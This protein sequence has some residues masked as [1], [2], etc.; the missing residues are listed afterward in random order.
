MR[1]VPFL[2]ILSG[3][4][5]A[6]TAC[7]EMWFV[8]NLAFDRAGYCFGSRLGA[9]VFDNSDCI[10]TQITLAPDVREATAM[11]RESEAYLGCD[12]NTEATGLA[13]SR[14]PL[15]RQ[16]SDLPIPTEYD[17]SACLGWTGPDI[18]LRSGHAVD[19]LVV[20]SAQAGLDIVWE[21][22]WLEN[23]GWEFISVYRDGEVLAMGWS[24]TPVDIDL[25]THLAG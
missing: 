20:G 23:P 21:Y 24:N 15:L 11:I 4:A 12:V 3:P 6:D 16:L 19:A 7:D 14:M 13:L 10:G 2:L 17:G 8:R 1:I 9:A 22:E 25:C 5:C 18:P